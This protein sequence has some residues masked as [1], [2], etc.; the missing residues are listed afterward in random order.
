M[1]ILVVKMTS[2]GDVVHTLPAVTDMARQFPG[3]QIDWLVEAPFAGIVS[4]HPAVARVIPVALRKWR[5]RWWAANT[6]VAVAAAKQA[7]RAQHY[8]LIIDFQ[9]LLKSAWW[10]R[11]A[12]GPVAGYDRASIREPLAALF[13]QRRAAVARTQNAVTR[14]RQLAAQH[15]GYAVQGTPDFRIHAPH[16]AWRAPAPCAVLMPAASRPEKLWPQEDWF[17]VVA[18]LKKRGLTPV[19]LWGSQE[20]HA[21]A[22]QLADATGGVVP[23][24]LSVADAAAVLASA[25]I[26][27][28]LD[29]GFTH[30]AAALNVPTIGIYCDHDPGLAAVTGHA[31]T[32]S[33]GGKGTPPPRGDVFAAID[34]ALGSHA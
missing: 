16:G 34:K 3:A 20:E 10:A 33:L 13:Y 9:G 17:A 22:Q 31:F 24:F 8:D 27:V 14:C 29:T 18:Q 1:R 12:I 19:F 25:Q 11:K 32:A 4:L 23:P 28:G 5:K 2:M 7:L 15:L 21:R 26:V 30:L 6:R